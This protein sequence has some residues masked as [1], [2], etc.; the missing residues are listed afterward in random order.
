MS[1]CVCV[2]VCVRVFV[3]LFVL[4]CYTCMWMGWHCMLL[5][6]RMISVCTK[7]CKYCDL[8]HGVTD[9][10]C[11]HHHPSTHTTHRKGLTA[12]S[13]MV[14]LCAFLN[15]SARSSL[16]VFPSSPRGIHSAP[17]VVRTKGMRLWSSRRRNW[18]R[19]LSLWWN[20]LRIA[21]GGLCPRQHGS[22]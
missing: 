3:C 8:H 21:S 2:C 1:V 7:V 4:V 19:K 22:K 16:S 12:T 6:L 18:W 15:L 9:C 10:G 17:N 11:C 13:T 5:R 20:R 14:P